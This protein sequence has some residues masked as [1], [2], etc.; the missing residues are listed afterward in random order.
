MNSKKLIAGAILI[1]FAL[2][3]IVLHL[4]CSNLQESSRNKEADD[5]DPVMDA[6]FEELNQD[7]EPD[8]NGHS[9]DDELSQDVTVPESEPQPEIQSS[10]AS[11][12]VST[13]NGGELT[14]LG[15]DLEEFDFSHAWI[16]DDRE[17]A[18]IQTKDTTG[19]LYFVGNAMRPLEEVVDGK[20]LECE[21]QGILYEVSE[22][23]ASEKARVQTMNTA[24]GTGYDYIVIMV[25]PI[26]DS[27]CVPLLEFS[28]N[29]LTDEDGTVYAAIKKYLKDR[30]DLEL[31]EAKTVQGSSEQENDTPAGGERDEPIIVR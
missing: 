8:E 16:S 15:T 30:F 9:E 20:K 17:Q 14:I 3:S 19:I 22:I 4:F 28:V 7:S 25:A 18:I 11:I 24:A 26:M 23:A 10:A 5:G 31:P 13:G 27:E 1:I 6:D 2:V 12:T 29:R 21:D